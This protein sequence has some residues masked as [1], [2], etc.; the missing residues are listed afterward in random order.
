MH[1]PFCMRSCLAW[2]STTGR[3]KPILAT[4]FD[5]RYHTFDGVNYFI[6]DYVHDFLLLDDVVCL[7]S[8][9]NGL[10]HSVRFEQIKKMMDDGKEPKNFHIPRLTGE[11]LPKK[12]AAC[13]ITP[14]QAKHLKVRMSKEEKPLFKKCL[15]LCFS[16]LVDP[17][18]FRYLERQVNKI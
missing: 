5:D 11:H 8:R 18:I 1:L 2:D 12:K 16:N 7:A 9:N 15:N 10:F 4:V 6:R 13:D 3:S 17:E 14:E